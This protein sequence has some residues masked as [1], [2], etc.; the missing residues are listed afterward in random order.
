M[1]CYLDGE[2]SNKDRARLERHLQECESC[3]Q[4]LESMRATVELLRQMEAPSRPRSIR[5]PQTAIQRQHQARRL[6]GLY[7]GIRAGAMAVTV[8]LAVLLSRDALQTAGL[9]KNAEAPAYEMVLLE[10]PAPAADTE[11][12][13]MMREA[14]RDAGPAGENAESAAVIVEA[15][16]EA[17]VEALGEAE[18]LVE[19][20]EVDAEPPPVAALLAA[21]PEEDEAPSGG[22]GTAESESSAA[23][24]LQ[25]EPESAETVVAGEALPMQKEASVTRPS[26]DDTASEAHA[27]VER[28]GMGIS[29]SPKMLA[30]AALAVI[31]VVL[32]GLTLWLGRRRVRL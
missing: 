4:E 24:A 18:A 25:A 23:L 3:R 14:P 22:G 7:V 8:L 15:E 28:L 2:L 9:A 20:Q 19:A 13:T 5:I 6:D 32:T 16:E 29:W 26:E 21:E 31:L 12:A 1:S 17:E 27:P 11:G 10:E 30:Y